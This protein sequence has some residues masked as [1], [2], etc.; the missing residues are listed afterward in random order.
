MSQLYAV[1][2]GVGPGTGA[3]VAKK[4]AQAYPVILL[5]RTLSKLKPI[6]QEIVNDGGQAISI[7]ADVSRKDSMEN[8]LQAVTAEIGSGYHC[9]VSYSLLRFWA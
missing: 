7:E 4:F 8:A 3:A 9:A 6:E 1:I 2:A 5:G